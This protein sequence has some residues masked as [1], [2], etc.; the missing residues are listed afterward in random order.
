MIRL[1][2][3]NHCLAAPRRR[4]VQL[5]TPKYTPSCTP[6]SAS[7]L[8]GKICPAPTARLEGIARS[9]PVGWYDK[10]CGPSRIGSHRG[11]R[12]VFGG[13]K[14]RCQAYALQTAHCSRS[15]C[16]LVWLILLGVERRTF[17][18]H[19]TTSRLWVAGCPPLL[20]RNGC[21]TMSGKNRLR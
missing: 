18:S 16:L 9:D 3:P 11:I 8:R 14:D 19:T 20:S 13:L 1:Q 7:L 21:V 12:A 4:I 10:S 5:T 15:V 17:S 2:A 6:N